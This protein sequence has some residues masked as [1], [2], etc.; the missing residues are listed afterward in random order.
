MYKEAIISIITIVIIVILNCVT[1]NYTSKSVSDLS[2]QLIE[3]RKFIS[4]KN[5]DNET[6]KNKVERIFK[7]WY[8]IY[9]LLAYY[10][11]HDELE[12]IE[13]NLTSLKGEIETEEYSEAVSELDR[14]MFV[15]RH[16]EE[17]NK[18]DLKNIF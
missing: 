2:N 12:K 17:K 9:N 15:L 11:E 18:F 10:L 5:Q 1:E 6:A 16:I 3:L 8:K 14:T 4:E 13:T 7:T